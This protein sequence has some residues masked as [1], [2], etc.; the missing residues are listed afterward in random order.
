VTVSGILDA[1]WLR[2]H[3]L[4]VPPENTDKNSRGRVLLIGGSMLVPGGLTLTAEAAFRAGAGKVQIALPDFLAVPTGMAL[5]EAGIRPLPSDTNGEIAALPPLEGAIAEAGCLAI[6]PAMGSPEAAALVVKALLDRKERPSMLLLDAAAI[7]AAAGQEARLR[8]MS[9]E[10]TLTPHCGEMASLLERE[11]EAVEA[12]REGVVL[13]AARRFNAV[14]TLKGPTT[15][16]ATPDG[17]VLRYGGGGVGLATGGSGDVLT[18]LIA[19]LAARGLPAWEATC[20]GVWLHGEAGRRLAERHG[21]MGF[22]AR[23]LPAEVPSLM[24]G[25]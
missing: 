18:G 11:P 22:L 16:I 15:L 13:E 8:D 23:E 6:G 21:P 12:D 24:R 14:V 19:G 3:P 5:P 4:P 9:G 25:V 2:V 7:A 1:A 10:L 20:W 17:E